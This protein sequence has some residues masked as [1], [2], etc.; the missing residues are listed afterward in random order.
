MKNKL[1]AELVWKQLEDHL[2]PGLSLTAIERTVYAHLLRHSRLEG[3]LRL[4][5][6]IRW[7]ARNIGLSTGPVRAAVRRLTAQGALR[8]VQRSKA[9]HVV[10]VRLPEEIRAERPNP[11]ESRAEAGE[12]M[13]DAL[14]AV[15]I[16]E[17]DFLQNITLRK[18]I[19]AREG[20]K[21]FYCLR[22]T[23]TAVQCLDHVV[24]QAQSGSN[25]YRNL[26][27][28]CL[29]C[30]SQKGEKPAHDFLRWLYREGHLNS[31]ELAGRIRALDDLASGK[32]RPELPNLA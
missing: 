7:L 26:V 29:E 1:N 28:S 30:N 21:C 10:E 24:P 13:A 18:A 19:H 14:A 12:D 31:G 5:F 27:S 3:K 11:I 9:G 17:A 23:S 32:L 25:S 8:L 15:N 4:R 2:A 6:S 16:E 22:R 20:G